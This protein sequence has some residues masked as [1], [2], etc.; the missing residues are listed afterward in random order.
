[1]ILVD[2]HNKENPLERRTFDIDEN[3]VPEGMTTVQPHGFMY[4]P[5]LPK[6]HWD[7]GEHDWILDD[8]CPERA[9]LNNFR[10]VPAVSIRRAM[11]QLP[12]PNNANE[13]GRSIEDDLDD[14]F[15]QYPKFEKEWVVAYPSNLID[16]SD[17]TVQEAMT[18]LHVNIDGIKRII[19]DITSE[20]A[21][22]TEEE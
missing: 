7:E 5:D 4:Y 18:L 21:A 22:E 1:M 19:L 10:R 13:P 8:D 16:L 12:S 20:D 2:I 3:T 17:R 15:K 14:L 9:L 11:R 6:Q